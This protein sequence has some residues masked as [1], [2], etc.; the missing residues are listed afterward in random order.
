MREVENLLIVFSKFRV[1]V[2]KGY[3]LRFQH[4]KP[5]RSSDVVQEKNSFNL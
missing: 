4:K 2:M 5:L 3:F 1:C